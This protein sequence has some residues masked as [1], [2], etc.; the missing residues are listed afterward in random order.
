MFSAAVL[1]KAVVILL[2]IV[3]LIA[4]TSGMVFLVKDKGDSDRTVKSLTVRIALSVLLFA[5]LI[6]G[7]ATGLIEPHGIQPPQTEKALQ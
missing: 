5:L 2:L 4:L 3:I 7:F 1:F 6:F